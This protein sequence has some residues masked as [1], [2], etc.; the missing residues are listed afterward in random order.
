MARPHAIKALSIFSHGSPYVPHLRTAN[1]ARTCFTTV[2]AGDP[3]H[4]PRF[5]FP[6]PGYNPPRPFRS[7]HALSLSLSPGCRSICDQKRP[8]LICL[9]RG[10]DRGIPYLDWIWVFSIVSVV[11]FVVFQ[12][13][14]DLFSFSLRILAT[15]IILSIIHFRL[16]LRL[17][18][19]ILGTND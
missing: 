12:F 18:L 3:E 7:P 13:Q 16:L 1:H 6:S 5:A 19:F 4:P 11:V 17:L 14:Y 2:H 10:D 9:S 15:L 8:P